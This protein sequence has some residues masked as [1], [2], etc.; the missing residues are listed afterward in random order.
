MRLSPYI[1]SRIGI[2]FAN[3]AKGEG[4]SKRETKFHEL[5]LPSRLLY[6]TNI[7]K[8][9]SRSKWETK[10]HELILPSRLLYSTNIVKGEGRDK[11]I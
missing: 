5:I 9:E 6:S 10:F 2:A 7:V 11:F 1:F 8:G 4:R 3:I